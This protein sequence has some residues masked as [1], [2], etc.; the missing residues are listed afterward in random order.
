MADR[1]ELLERLRR[2]LGLGGNGAA[3][4]EPPRPPHAEELPPGCE[5][6]ED[7]P[8]EEAARRV[9][10]YLD[11]E[12]AEADAELVRCHVARCERCY[13]MF[14]WEELFLEVVRESGRRPEPD[15]EL[16]RRV[17]ELL[18]RETG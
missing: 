8:C 2:L 14:N 17:D 18:D 9:Y 13:P 3:A 6:V 16:R 7:I 15:E 4:P 12:L 10:E 1:P 11:G 5:E